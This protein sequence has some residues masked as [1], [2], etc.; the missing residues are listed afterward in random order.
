MLNRLTFFIFCLLVFSLPFAQPINFNYSGSVIQISEFLFLTNFTIFLIGVLLKKIPVKFSKVYAIFGF[1]L[2]ALFVSAFFSVS[3][4]SSFTKLAGAFYLVGLFFLAFNL[5]DKKERLKKVVLVWLAAT[6]IVS[7]IGTL[8]VL[9]FYI[10]RDN[11]LM[12]YT[13]HH[14]GTLIPGNYPRIQTTFYYPAMLCNYL[15]ISLVFAF[16][17]R[18]FK[19]INNLVFAVLIILIFITLIFTITPGLGGIAIIVG[20]IFWKV[21][22]SKKIISRTILAAGILI[23]ATFF[24]AGIISPIQTPTSPY[25]FNIPIIEKRIDPSV[26]LLTW[27][28]SVKTFLQNPLTGKGIGTPVAK[29]FYKTASGQNQML[30]DAHQIWFSIAA[31][32]GIFG[33][34]AILLIT[35]YFSKKSFSFLQ[36]DKSSLLFY[37]AVAFFGTFLF[38][39]LVGSFEDARHLWIFFGLFIAVSNFQR[40]EIYSFN[41]CFYSI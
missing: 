36:Y 8:T 35:H 11:F 33:L 26:R 23:S 28:S 40:N 14:Y 2:F 3:V 20:I 1:Y 24:I 30:N 21:F 6:F 9:L 15:S 29:V 27:E 22:R 16:V 13:L 31:Q 18:Q 25:F 39:G 41:L 17:A 10:Q 32:A 34:A 19:W 12:E 4:V 37:F 5:V 7:S 38:Q